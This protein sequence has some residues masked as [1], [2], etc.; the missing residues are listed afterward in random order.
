MNPELIA[1]GAFDTAENPLWHPVERR[2][3]WTDIPRGKLFRFDPSAVA[4]EECYRGN[5]VGGFTIQ[6]DGAL[7]LFMARGAIARWRG[8]E[9]DFLRRETAGEEDGRF[10]DVI[11]DPKGRVYCGTMRTAAHAGRLYRMEQDGS[12]HAVL[13]GLGT[14]NGMGFM[15]DGK[16]MYFTDSHA[17]RIYLFDYDDTTGALTN[18]RIWLE[19]PENQ[20]VPDGLTVDSEGFVWSARWN[21]SALYRYSPGAVEVDRIAFPARKVSCI[22]FGGK[23]YG[24]AFVTTALAGGTREREGGGAG[25]LFRFR[26]GVRGVPEFH[27]RV[28][29]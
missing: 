22:S 26:P 16:Q 4:W 3:Y 7:L 18:Q 5:P 25:A 13:D 12:L 24:E 21:G 19:I 8:G 10:N 9:P 17:R 15:P 20:G 29:L 11:A 2:L 23:E 27:S 14:P 1:D 28:G 6:A